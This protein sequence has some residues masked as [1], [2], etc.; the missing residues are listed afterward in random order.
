M[1]VAMMSKRDPLAYSPKQRAAG[2]KGAKEAKAVLARAKA[3]APNWG[4]LL[5]SEDDD[6]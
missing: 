3:S 5:N 6:Q 4:A 1:T 2:L